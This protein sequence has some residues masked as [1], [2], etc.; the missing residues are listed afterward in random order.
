MNIYDAGAFLVISPWLIRNKTVLNTFTIATQGGFTFWSGSNPDA[1]GTWYH[2]IEE[3]ANNDISEVKGSD[4]F[5]VT[6]LVPARNEE[7]NIENIV[8]L[9]PQMGSGTEIVFVEGNS[10]DN[11]YR[12]I[13]EVISLSP[14]KDIKLFK[15]PGKGKGDAVR[16]GF[17]NASGDILMILD[18]DLTVE[19][20]DLPKFYDALTKLNLKIIEIPVRYGERTYGETNINRF[21]DARLHGL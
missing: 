12:K 20:K 5:K 2:K 13:E 18:A 8:K 17:A 16:K 4:D 15:Q 14:D 21:R 11:T 3:I 7:G 1:T 9:I 10:T 6:V 19:P